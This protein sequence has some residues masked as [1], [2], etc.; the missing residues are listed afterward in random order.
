MAAR[1]ET[2]VSASPSRSAWSAPVSLG[3]VVNSPWEDALAALSKDGRSL[4]FTSNRPPEAGGDGSFDIW[5][6]HRAAPDAPWGLPVNLGLPVNTPAAE[7]G[8]NL[9]RDG[10]WLFFHRT[11]ASGDFDLMVSWRPHTH[12]DF[13]WQEPV[14]LGPGVNG[15]ANDAGAAYF[16]GDEGSG[17]ELFFGSNRLGGYDLFVSRLTSGGSFGPATL[18]PEL[19]SGAGDQRPAISHDGKEMFFHSNRAGSL[20]GSGDIWRS[21]RATVFDAWTTPTNVAELNTAAF[22]GQPALSADGD[23]L[24]FNSSGPG[25]LGANDL[26]VATRSRVK[27]RR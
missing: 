21:T 19:S 22:E 17:A 2:T 4:Y 8:P 20:A 9:S 11:T 3:S 5:V 25:G 12:D 10:H 15:T 14:N 27:G 6:S 24:V 26:Y 1:S 16:A 7:A 18:I 13:G 23:T